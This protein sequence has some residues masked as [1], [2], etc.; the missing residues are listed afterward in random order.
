MLS[1]NDDETCAPQI[2]FR[3]QYNNNRTLKCFI[4]TPTTHYVNPKFPKLTTDDKFDVVSYRSTPVK[5][6]E[7]W[8]CAVFSPADVTQCSNSSTP[9]VQCSTP[10]SSMVPSPVNLYAQRLLPTPPR[11]TGDH[12][13]SPR[14]EGSIASGARPLHASPAS[15]GRIGTPS[16]LSHPSRYDSSLGKLTKQFVHILRSSPDNSLDLNR[17][18]S[19]LGVQK[20]RIY[21]ITVSQK[22]FTSSFTVELTNKVSFSLIECA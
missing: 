19:E 3:H 6:I 18:A 16:S 1:D 14:D 11:T 15:S 4:I 7:K 20:R 5:S 17:A 12:G 13:A 22:T 2:S 21:D 10:L 9:R 8:N